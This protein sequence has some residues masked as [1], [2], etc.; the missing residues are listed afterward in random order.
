MNNR[1]LKNKL[2]EL[3]IVRSA[4]MP[5]ALWISETRNSL[6]AKARAS[7]SV[8]AVAAE[9]VV[10]PRG[11]FGSFMFVLRPVVAGF[12][13]IGIGIAG[14]AAGVSSSFGLAK[15]DAPLKNAAEFTQLTFTADPTARTYLHLELAGRRANEFASLIE[16]NDVNR[17]SDVKVAMDALQDELANVGLNLDEV[18]ASKPEASAAVAKAVDRKVAEINA[19]FGKT[20]NLLGKDARAQAEA[21][22]AAADDVSIKAVAVLVAGAKTPADKT[23]AAARVQ[24]KIESTEKDMQVATTEASEQ[25]KE[26]LKA[27]KAALAKDDLAQAITKVQEATEKTEAPAV[28]EGQN[29]EDAPIIVNGNANSN[30]NA[31]NGKIKAIGF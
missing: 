5:N 1:E 16:S 10:M 21:V 29:N 14:W 20:K 13:V 31:E 4:A 18:N 2:A 17:D 28:T 30:V 6:V 24:D 25:A 26:A 3:R 9:P 11:V 15:N 27:A 23:D 8:Q 12:M 22:V 7:S 19:V